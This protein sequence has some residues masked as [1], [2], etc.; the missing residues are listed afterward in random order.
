M[1]LRTI[2]DFMAMGD[3]TS[4]TDHV[5]HRLELLEDQ[6]RHLNRVVRIVVRHLKLEEANT[7]ATKETLDRLAADVK[8]NTDATAAAQ[9]A[10]N[11]FVQ[12]VADL[13]K[14]LQDAI[15]NNDEAAI[16]AA[17]DAIEANNVALTAAVPATASAVVENT[18]SDPSA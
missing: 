3:R 14:Q 9:Q 18:D 6:V 13:T 7:M 5:P 11:G 2:R 16:K 15:A 8:A 1:L 17:A 12:T 10:L 4:A